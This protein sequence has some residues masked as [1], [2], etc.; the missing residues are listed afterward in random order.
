MA[1]PLVPVDHPPIDEI[2]VL[3]DPDQ[4]LVTPQALAPWPGRLCLRLPG[5]PLP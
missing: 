4:P 2:P 5:D 3:I 1:E